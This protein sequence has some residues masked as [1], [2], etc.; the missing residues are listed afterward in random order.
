MPK[1]RIIRRVLGVAVLTGAFAWLGFGAISENHARAVAAAASDRTLPTALAILAEA[2]PWVNAPRSPD[3]RGKV[4]LVN[5]WTYSCINSLRPLPYLHAWAGKY[6]DDGLVVI[7]VHAP[8]FG[9]EK[10]LDNVRNAVAELGV[11]YPVLLDRDLAV[12]RAFG[13]QGWPGFVFIDAT[14]HV[15]D[16]RLGEGHYAESERLLQQLLGEAKGA[17]V[18]KS[19]TAVNGK[20]AQAAPDWADLGS[21]ETY[22]GYGQTRNFASPEGIGKDTPRQYRTPATMPRNHWGLG[23]KWSVGR[24]SAELRSP[25]GTIGY[26]FHARDLHL[27][28]GAAPEG[29]PVRF[30]VTIDGN[31]PGADHGA[32]IDEQG[33]GTVREDRLYQLVRQSRSVTDRN[34]EITFFA[35]GVRAYAFTFG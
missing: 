27:V 25:S 7:G 5:F 1:A 3:L 6:R 10:D 12:W 30:R 24:E 35:P 13:N 28:L 19:I 33:W 34:F 14:G 9:F 11:N 2:S 20:G 18:S 4:V 31:A 17:S 23:G 26:R 22:V 21:P 32:D 15:R 16:Y 29:R 8:E